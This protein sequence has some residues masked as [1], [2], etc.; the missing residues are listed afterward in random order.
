MNGNPFYVEPGGNLLPGLQMLSGGIE[1]MQQKKAAQAAQQA[2]QQAMLKGVEIY[3]SG[4]INKAREFQMQNPD[5][6][7]KMKLVN[8]MSH[9]NEKTYKNSINAQYEFLA[10][11]T[12]ENAEQLIEKREQA[13]D[14]EGVPEEDRL[15]TRAFIQKFE[16]DP[17]GTIKDV[18]ANLMADDID[19]YSKYQKATGAGAG[20]EVAGIQEFEYLTQGLSGEDKTAAR[21]VKLGLSPRATESAEAKALKVFKSEVAKLEARLGLEP[22][23]AG[24]VTAAKN[25]ATAKVKEAGKEKSN[26]M[27]W[28]VYNSSM[29]N[30][31][32]AMRGTETGPVV[33]FIPAMTANQQ[34]AEGAVAVMAPILKQMFRSAGEGT[35]T[36][37]DQ[38][39]LMGMLPTRKDLPEAREAKI[40]AIDSI[41]RAKLGIA[42]EQPEVTKPVAEMSTEELLKAAGIGG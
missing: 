13:L 7:E 2:E 29:S 17:E 35:F 4:D 24:A 31:A 34:I 10:N 15:E 26:D 18:R 27:A 22:E 5:I 33:G 21:R 19:R 41:V 40:I 1:Q 36:D 38:D 20:M 12:K 6:A 37:K 39:M 14:A 8:V 11:P 25:E 16:A 42:P 30:L 23:V 32:T 3:R 28:D 9:A